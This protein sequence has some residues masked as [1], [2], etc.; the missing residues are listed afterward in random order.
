MVH[1]SNSSS[2]SGTW[3]LEARK[4]R[5]SLGALLIEDQPLLYMTLSQKAE[6]KKKDMLKIILK[7]FLILC[8]F[9]FVF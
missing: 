5:L 6:E 9:C 8:V 7:A 3:H 2:N 1:I 4:S